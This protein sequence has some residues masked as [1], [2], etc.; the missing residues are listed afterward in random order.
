MNLLTGMLILIFI[1]INYFYIDA[2]QAVARE[3]KGLKRAMSQ[4]HTHRKK[5]GDEGNEGNEDQD[6]R[7][8]E[9]ED[10]SNP[11]IKIKQLVKSHL[12][13]AASA[14]AAES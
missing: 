10:D 2:Y 5:N 9:G 14:L 7:D 1:V 4:R 8:K 12:T 6:N 13:S 3:L 11:L